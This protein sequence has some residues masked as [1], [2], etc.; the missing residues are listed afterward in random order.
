MNTKP[1]FFRSIFQALSILALMVMVFAQAVSPVSAQSAVVYIM[2]NDQLPEKGQ[3]VIPANVGYRAPAELHGLVVTLWYGGKNDN[4]STMLHLSDG[5]AADRVLKYGDTK[6]SYKTVVWDG[7]RA[8]ISDSQ[9]CRPD[10]YSD[11]VVLTEGV[12][13]G[14]RCPI[15]IEYHIEHFVPAI[16]NATATAMA[17]AATA[18]PTATLAFTPTPSVEAPVTPGATAS[19][20]TATADPMVIPISGEVNK[21]NLMGWIIGALALAVLFLAFRRPAA[22]WAPVQ[23]TS[24]RRKPATKKK[25]AKR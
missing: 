22:V 1:N 25:P 23:T 13:Y 12:V 3:L 11:S 17:P 8:P 24:A 2:S 7:E 5:L 21:I 4:V 6:E 9:N 15:V 10:F 19:Q 16:A 20:P 14:D 18:T